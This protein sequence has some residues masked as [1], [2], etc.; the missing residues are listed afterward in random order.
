[1]K[2]LNDAAGSSDQGRSTWN[3]VPIPGDE[4]VQMLLPLALSNEGLRIFPGEQRA[5][6]NGGARLFKGEFEEISAGQG[7]F[8]SVGSADKRAPW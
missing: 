2:E 5:R 6:A 3:A 8:P 4:G 7:G 1:M